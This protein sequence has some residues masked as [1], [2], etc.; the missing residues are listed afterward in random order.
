MNVPGPP[1]DPA[2]EHRLKRFVCCIVRIE[3]QIVA[4][5]NEAAGTFA[6]HGKQAGQGGQ[7]FPVNFDQHE[8]AVGL[9]RDGA[10]YGLHQ[11]ALAHAA[12]APQKS[13]IRRVALGEAAGIVEQ[14]IPRPVNSYQLF[15]IQPVY[16]GHRL[17]PSGFGMPCKRIRCPGDIRRGR[18]RCDSV[19]CIGYAGQQFGGFRVRHGGEQFGWKSAPDPITKT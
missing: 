18:G 13:V 17:E 6:Q 8:F 12:R 3:G 7:V 10:V 16:F 14:G 4:E 5:Q 1:L 15:D 19:Q 2:L 9:G 11:R